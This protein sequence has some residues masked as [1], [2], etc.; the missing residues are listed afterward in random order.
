MCMWIYA[1]KLFFHSYLTYIIIIES[2]Y[3]DLPDVESTIKY[4]LRNVK[5]PVVGNVFIFLFIYQ[6][7]L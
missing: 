5:D 4:E 1:C 7:K 6:S 3:E 2:K